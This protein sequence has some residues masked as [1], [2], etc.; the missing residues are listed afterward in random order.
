MVEFRSGFRH[1]ILAATV[2][3]C[4]SFYFIQGIWRGTQQIKS[5]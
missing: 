5:K 2:Q 3:V 1:L 4:L